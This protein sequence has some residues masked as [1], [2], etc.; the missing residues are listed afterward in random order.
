LVSFRIDGPTGGSNSNLFTWDT[1]YGPDTR[2]P[3]P[4][5]IVHYSMTPSTPEPTATATDTPGPT[6]PPPDPTDGPSPTATDTP[7]V[8]TATATAPPTPERTATST[9]VP[10]IQP[11]PSAIEIVPASGDVGWVKEGELGN[12]FGDADTFT[13]YYQGYIYY[14]AVQFDLSAIPPDSS[15]TSARLTLSGRDKRYLSPYG[16]GRWQVAVLEHSADAGWRSHSYNSIRRAATQSL[17][18]PD[19]I[20]GDLD[21]GR[22]NTF[23][24]NDD[25]LWFLRER[26]AS[27]GKISLRFEGPRAGISN[28]FS[29]ATGYGGGEP[30]RLTV[31]LGPRGGGDNPAPTP[32]PIHEEKLNRLVQR[33]NEEREKAGVA[34]VTVSAQLNSAAYDH[35]V[36]MAMH[37]FFSH[38]GSDG[39]TPEER[40]ARAGFQASA[41]G[42]VLAAAHSDPDVIVDAWLARDQ[43]GVILD[44]AFTHVGSAY[45][46]RTLTAYRHYWTVKLALAAP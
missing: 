23:L 26:A 43:R 41:T 19:L 46:F 21:V 34:P 40:V 6:D 14:G 18:R 10:T 22:S 45:M 28:V 5:L 30:P 42:E 35:T 27:T 32:D 33:I 20:Q 3:G 38:T 36:D 16:N 8:P 1:G 17:L 37:D 31:V 13:G 15:I 29:W 12:H 9:E 4:K 7:V 2:Y 24:F 39:S 44:P 25:Q 11:Q